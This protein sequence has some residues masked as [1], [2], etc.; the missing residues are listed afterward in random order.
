MKQT[1][2]EKKGASP[3]RWPLTAFLMA[4]VLSAVLTLAS[5][6]MLD[7]AGMAVA[8]LILLLFI[9]LG[10]LFDIV[11]TA[12]MSADPRPFH[13]MASHKERGAK[14]A[15]MLLRNADR[16]SNICNDVVGD[17]CGIVSGATGAVMAESI[18]RAFSTSRIAGIFSST[19]TSAVRTVATIMGSAA[20]LKPLML[21]EPRRGIPPFI[22]IFSS[23]SLKARLRILSSLSSK[24]C[25]LCHLIIYSLYI[26]A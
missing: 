21:T 10:I 20:F 24:N 5:E 8:L 17:I 3:N 4:V 13:S 16:V 6:A 18:S 25:I 22:T 1:K 23:I 12:V 15:L 7:G 9:G 14:Q 26:V 11:G 19:Q 2:K